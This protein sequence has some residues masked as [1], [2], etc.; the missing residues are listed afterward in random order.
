[1]VGLL[2]VLLYFGNILHQCGDIELNPGPNPRRGA[3]ATSATSSADGEPS[4]RDVMDLLADIKGDIKEMKNG[5]ANLQEEVREVR[6]EVS[7]VW[8]MNNELKSENDVLKTKVER[9]EAKTDDLECRSKRNNVMFYGL[10]REEN[11][12]WEDCEATVRELIVD[13]LELAG[14]IQFDRVHRVSAKP[15]SPVI[16]RCCFYKDKELILKAK[17]KLKGSDIFIG[18]DFSQR[19]RDIRK[20]LTPH[21][22]AAQKD[23]KKATMIYDHLVINGKKCVVDKDDRLHERK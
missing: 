2:L 4:L 19:V 13:K 21:L 10:P 23:G 1:M 8:R 5:F 14:D 9:L 18:E 17:R 11:E 22:K 15:D 7:E 12:K 16:A 3:S 20:K 6:E